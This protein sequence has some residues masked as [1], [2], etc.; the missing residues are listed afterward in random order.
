MC[1][2]PGLNPYL[3]HLLADLLGPPGALRIR[4]HQF[5]WQITP[6][7]RLDSADLD[8]NT[9]QVSGTSILPHFNILQT[10]YA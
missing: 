4:A 5:C 9:P 2:T 6:Y 10:I 1:L 8:Y 3:W 7:D